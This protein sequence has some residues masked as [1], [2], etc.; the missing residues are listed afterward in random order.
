MSWIENKELFDLMQSFYTL[1]GI[2]IAL[3][4]E[5]YNLIVQYP[6]KGSGF[7]HFM[8]QNPEFN[9][10][11]LASD[12]EAFKTCQKSNTL[13]MYKCHAGLIE[14][15]APIVHDGIISG[16]I[17]LGQISDTKDKNE[18]LQMITNLCSPYASP[19]KIRQHAKSIKYKN[20]KQVISAAKILESCTGYIQLKGMIRPSDSE[21]LKQINEFIDDHLNEQITVSRLCSHFHISRTSLYDATN[22]H[23][24]GGLARY[25][26]EK[27][28]DAAKKLLEVTDLPISSVSDK[29]GFSDYNYFSRVFKQRYKVSP[30]NFRTK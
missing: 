19:E 26:K 7:C 1:T 20:A 14:A 25:I 21:L 18:F 8:R 2:L 9:K 3:F 15:T 13:T 11:C 29:V 4:D 5:K 30:K 22:Q 23:T 16:Y 27:R 17:M 24:N 12:A 6:A 28:L 10:K